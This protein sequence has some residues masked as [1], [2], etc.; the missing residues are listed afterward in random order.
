MNMNRYPT[1][2]LYMDGFT[3]TIYQG[4]ANQNPRDENSVA[5]LTVTAQQDPINNLH[6][7]AGPR[8]VKSEQ[9]H[10]ADYEAD[11][12]LAQYPTDCAE[13]IV[14]YANGDQPTPRQEGYQAW[15]TKYQS[16]KQRAI[17]K[18][19]AIIPFIVKHGAIMR[20]DS[21]YNSHGFLHLDHKTA[22][23]HTFP[24]IAR[25]ATNDQ[26]P[27]LNAS[28]I[29]YM[30]AVIE[31]EW[32][33]LQEHANLS[34]HSFT[35]TTPHGST[36]DPKTDH[37]GYETEQFVQEVAMPELAKQ[38]GQPELDAIGII[39]TLFDR[40]NSDAL[41]ADDESDQPYDIGYAHAAK[42][43]ERILR[44][45]I[46]ALGIEDLIEEAIYHNAGF[47]SD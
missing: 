23:A 21:I 28:L 8:D 32:E 14:T 42:A 7:L 18:Y 43:A 45:E 41:G 39:A 2:E 25:A 5:T 35:I 24:F 47:T 10:N 37:Y 46:Q 1:D 34:V 6:R 11:L 22:L 36:I 33:Q 3:A 19:M 20:T 40:I 30:H 4:E 29:N 26:H 9:T 16:E 13:L 27:W 44:E 17:Q 15:L 12:L 38:S 31:H